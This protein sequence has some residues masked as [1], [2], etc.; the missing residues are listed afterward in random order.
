MKKDLKFSQLVLIFFSLLI[1]S[2]AAY[3]QYKPLHHPNLNDYS[4]PLIKSETDA[5]V[6]VTMDSTIKVTMADGV[7]LEA[8]R[9]IPSGPVPSGGYKTVI[10]VH[11]YGDNMRTLYGFASGQAS[12]GYYVLTFSMRGQ[13]YSGGL[14]N[15]ISRTEAEDMKRIVNYVKLDTLHGSQPNN[16]LIMGGSQGGLVP[17]QAACTGMTVKTLITSVATPDFATSWIE[18]GCI[19]MTLL[20]TVSYTPDSARYTPEVDNIRY[21]IYQ[22]TKAAWN[23]L[24]TTLPANRDFTNIVQNNHNPILIENAWQ[25]R[26]FNAN[27]NIRIIPQLTA[28]GAPLF[29]MYMGAVIG[30]GGDTSGAET[31]WHEKFFNDWFFYYLWENWPGVQDLPQREKFHQAYTVNPRHD[32][33]WTFKHDSSMTN[34]FGTT[35]LKLYFEKNKLKTEPEN[36][37]HSEKLKNDVKNDFTMEDAVDEEFTGSYFTDNFKKATLKFD[38][39]V[40]TSDVKMTGT[41]VIN[42][43]YESNAN[44]FCQ[45]NYQIYEVNSN[46]SQNFVTRVNYTDRNYVKNSIRTASVN[47]VAHS[48]IFKA[49]SKIRIILTNLDTDP[50]DNFL[51]TNPFVLPVMEKATHKIYF[52]GDS[53]I[54]I[55][56]RAAMDNISGIKQSTEPVRLFENFPNPFNPETKIRFEL[57]SEFNGNVSL[58]VYDIL[59]KEIAVIYNGKLQQGMHEFTFSSAG[60]T[61]GVYFYALN[62]GAST[63]VRKMLVVK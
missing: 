34:P 48:H 10:M 51:R 18:N 54:S 50:N 56:T 31:R 4:F 45:F 14:S 58:K 19:K 52:S 62:T 63:Q 27:G 38:S 36:G 46:G 16:I 26:F 25:D 43:K 57:P 24:A 33:M 61:S 7:K 49:G 28:T 22:D 40:L 47:G 60:L 9:F 11:G 23:N 6:P 3:A 13:G 41:P 32:N 21:W 8:T 1:L 29:R 15:L 20:W 53:Y 5:P 12:F 59:G 42:M 30:H 37:N 2:S 35:N 17:W 39:D 44:N 55:P